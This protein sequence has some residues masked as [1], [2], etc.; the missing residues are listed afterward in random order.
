MLTHQG[1]DSDRAKI[2]AVFEGDKRGNGHRFSG[3]GYSNRTAKGTA[4]GD[5][6]QSMYAIFGPPQPHGGC[7]FD[8]GNAENVDPKGQ[9]GPLH[10]GSM[11]AIYFQY[12][13]LGGSRM[14]L[15]HLSPRGPHLFT[16]TM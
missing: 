12:G 6:P 16:P 8:Y 11:E 13:N 3:Q 5:A 10:D 1:S 4:V 14:L 7:C 15:C 2:A 9:A